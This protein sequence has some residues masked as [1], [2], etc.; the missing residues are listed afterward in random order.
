MQNCY[1]KFCCRKVGSTEEM[2]NFGDYWGDFIVLSGAQ[3]RRSEIWSLPGYPGELMPLLLLLKHFFAFLYG[4][5]F[6]IHLKYSENRLG[7]IF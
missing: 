5:Y 7:A 2:A 1:L 3:E 4:F 6:I